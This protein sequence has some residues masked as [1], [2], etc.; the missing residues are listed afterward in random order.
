MGRSGARELRCSSRCRTT[1]PVYHC[2]AGESA[3]NDHVQ[4]CEQ[5][6]CL[7]VIPED[8]GDPAGFKN[9]ELAGARSGVGWLSDPGEAGLE[10]DENGSTKGAFGALTTGVGVAATVNLSM[11]RP[12]CQNGQ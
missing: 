1:A 10:V 6:C 2:G 3:A 11:A 12:L 7:Q 8:V 9:V 5:H 4:L